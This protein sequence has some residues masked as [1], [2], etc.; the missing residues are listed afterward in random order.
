VSA[1]ALEIASGYGVVLGDLG[2]ARDLLWQAHQ[3]VRQ[4]RHE[5]PTRLRRVS[6]WTLE[7]PASVDDSLGQH[8]AGPEAVG[9]DDHLSGAVVQPV[10]RCDLAVPER[11]G[12]VG[13]TTGALRECAGW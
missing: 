1:T 11:V 3:R 7:E 10:G 5:A 6:S 9:E 4:A 12:C 2:V 8:G 13:E